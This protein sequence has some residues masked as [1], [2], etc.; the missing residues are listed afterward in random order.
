MAF[1]RQVIIPEFFFQ[2]LFT[3]GVLHATQEEEGFSAQFRACS[4][5]VRCFIIFADSIVTMRTLRLQ[6]Q[7]VRPGMMTPRRV[8]FDWSRKRVAKNSSRKEDWTL[9]RMKA[10]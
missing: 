10:V 5:G 4:R 7:K 9:K 8:F 3:R 2:K 6:L 1:V